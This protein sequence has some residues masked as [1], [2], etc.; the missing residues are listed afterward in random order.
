LVRLRSLLLPLVPLTSLLGLRSWLLNLGWSL[1]PLNYLLGVL[2]G[3]LHLRVALVLPLG[4]LPQGLSL[5]L[6]VLNLGPLLIL[7]LPLMT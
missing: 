4:G 2:P 5:L 1:V 7:L 3:L 6:M